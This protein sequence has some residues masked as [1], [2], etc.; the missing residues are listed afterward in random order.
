MWYI[1]TDDYY[2]AMKR[3]KIPEKAGW[4][5]LE[6]TVL[7]EKSQ[8]IKVKYHMIPLIKNAQKR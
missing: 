5:N 8:I 6:N 3:K 1:Y 4:L 7:H 2:S